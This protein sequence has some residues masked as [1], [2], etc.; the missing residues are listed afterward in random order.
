[1]AWGLVGERKQA[2]DKPACKIACFVEFFVITDKT[3]QASTV[4]VLCIVNKLPQSHA[5]AVAGLRE[6]PMVS[7][8][9]FLDALQGLGAA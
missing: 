5:H 2:C 7:I 4:K 9:A 8:S 1:M 6:V 3:A